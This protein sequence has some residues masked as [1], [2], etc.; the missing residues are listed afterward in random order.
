VAV[1]DADADVAALEGAID[2]LEAGLEP[3]RTFVL[4]AGAEGAVRLHV[5]RTVVRRAERAVV[6]LATREPVD[7]AVVRYLN[8]LSDLLFV[9]AR[10]T[11]RAAGVPDVPWTARKAR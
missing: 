3:L 4:P 7:P 10:A 6:A 5:A 9:Q 8:R 2:A 11:N 1:A